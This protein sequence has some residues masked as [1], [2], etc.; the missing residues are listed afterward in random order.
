MPATQPND[1]LSEKCAVLR[2]Q[3]N[4]CATILKHIT[5]AGLWSA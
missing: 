1:A 3:S 4:Q 5:V 2:C